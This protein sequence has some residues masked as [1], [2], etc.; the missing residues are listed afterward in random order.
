MSMTPEAEAAAAA[1]VTERPR[2]LPNAAADRQA[3]GL[4]RPYLGLYLARMSSLKTA[5][6]QHVSLLRACR[7]RDAAAAVK[8]LEE[9]VVH[10]RD[11]VI[12]ALEEM[13]RARP[14]A[15]ARARAAAR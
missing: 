11:L 13:D 3:L 12:A 7:R 8:T 4:V 15:R 2:D 5:R 14:P 1:T 6:A 9:H 10:T